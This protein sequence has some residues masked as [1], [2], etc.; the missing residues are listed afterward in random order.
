MA[1]SPASTTSTPSIRSPSAGRA[2]PDM[3]HGRWYPTN[4]L[5][6]DGRTLIM[7]GLD[8]RGYGRQERGPRPVHAVALARRPRP[9]HAT[10]RLGRARQQRQAAGRRLL[11]APVLDAERTWARGRDRGRSTPG[12]SRRRQAAA[13]A[14]AGPPEHVGEPRLGHRGDAPGRARRLAPGRAAGRLRQA[15]GR[16]VRA[17]QDALATDSVSVFDERHPDAGWK[18]PAASGAAPCTSRARTPTPC[19]CP[20]GRW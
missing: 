14:L 7:G 17:D 6:P 15:Q 4:L 12:G 9:H 2:S 16:F 1:S 5:M 18:E 3:P 13:A 20:T 10:G 11:P 19:C 8:E